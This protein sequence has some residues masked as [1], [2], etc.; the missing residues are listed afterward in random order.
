VGETASPNVNILPDAASQEYT[1]SIKDVSL[2][3]VRQQ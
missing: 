2:A 3:S 1:A